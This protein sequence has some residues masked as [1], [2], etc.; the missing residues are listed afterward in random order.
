VDLLTVLSLRTPNALDAIVSREQIR[1]GNTSITVCTDRRA[2]DEI[3][4]SVPDPTGLAIEK[5]RRP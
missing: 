2:P 1:F 3:R 4:E 5:A